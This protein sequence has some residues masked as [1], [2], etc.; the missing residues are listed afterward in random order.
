MAKVAAPAA[1]VR[2]VVNIHARAAAVRVI[3]FH[4]IRHALTALATL[5]RRA[6]HST[7]A[8]ASTAVEVVGR[9]IGAFGV[10]IRIAAIRL[11]A[12]AL[13]TSVGTELAGAAGV[14]AVAAVA[15]ISFQ[16]YAMTIATRRMEGVFVF[17]GDRKAS[18]AAA[19]LARLARVAARSTISDVDIDVGASSATGVASVRTVG[20]VHGTG[21]TVS[22]VTG[23]SRSGAFVAAPAAI[24]YIAA[25][26]GASLAAIVWHCG[27][28][29]TAF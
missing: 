20:A 3:R 26:V 21:R 7:S 19:R 6:R 17:A 22:V 23:R 10:S 15:E 25:D 24:V 12:C 5:P 16:V 1:I 13:A 9:G 11:A 14:A 29:T 8:I 28:T 2:I 4:A 18:A 27:G